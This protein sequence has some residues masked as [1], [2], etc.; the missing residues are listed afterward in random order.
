[1]PD[2][3]DTTLF[4]TFLTIPEQD[5]DASTSQ[6]S[7]PPGEEEGWYLLAQIKDNM[8]I[9]KPTLILTDRDGNPFALVFE[10]LGR[11][12]LDLR[13]LGFKKGSTAIIA[14]ARRTRPAD[15][16][17]RGFV[18]IDK[19][20]SRSVG[21]VPGALARVLELGGKVKGHACENCAGSGEGSLRSCTGCGKAVY[22]SKECQV[23]G[24]TEGRH[25]NDCKILK[26][27]DDI[28]I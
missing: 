19:G 14:N 18:R 1:M 24:W 9:N 21:I 25:K 5:P 26:V 10:G 17:S 3:T 8:T 11:D 7:S 23:K 28:F 13:G 16:S 4:P 22:C 2:I 27:L 6:V 12:D 20:N 15:E